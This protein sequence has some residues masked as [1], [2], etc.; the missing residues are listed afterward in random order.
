MHCCNQTI[1][2]D[3]ATVGDQHTCR[4]AKSEPIFARISKRLVSGLSC[5]LLLIC[6]ILK[7][8]ANNDHDVA[9]DTAL[10]LSCF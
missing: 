4:H 7:K 1:E 9:N 5:P 2:W 10:A 8:L 3:A 6:L